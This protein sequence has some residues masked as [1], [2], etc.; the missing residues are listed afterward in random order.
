MDHFKYQAPSVRKEEIQQRIWTCFE[1][2]KNQVWQ[3][4]GYPLIQQT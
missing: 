1:H 3:A 2:K 4:Q